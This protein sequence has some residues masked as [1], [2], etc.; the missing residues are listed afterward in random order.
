M[1]ILVIGVAAAS[2]AVTALLAWVLVRLNAGALRRPQQA[3]G[4][5]VV[6]QADGGRPA[7][8]GG[9]SDGGGG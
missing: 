2:I 8:D 3:G 4:R 7:G 6:P 1:A 5:A 9:A